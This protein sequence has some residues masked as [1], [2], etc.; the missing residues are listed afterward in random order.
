[1]KQMHLSV[2]DEDFERIDLYAKGHNLSRSSFVLGAA[3]QVIDVER[4]A[5]ATT[6]LN[7]TLREYSKTGVINPEDEKVLDAITTL[8]ERSGYNV[9]RF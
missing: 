7:Q 3:L 1:M 5:N 4:W 6:V 9:G 8:L 2:S